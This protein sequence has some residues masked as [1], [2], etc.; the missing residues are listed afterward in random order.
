M[1]KNKIGIIILNYNSYQ[2]SKNC[3]ESI[4][5]YLNTINALIIVVDNASY[6]GS[7]RKLNLE[8]NSILYIRNKKNTGYT[9]GNNLGI[10]AAI[11]NGCNLF[12]ILNNDTRITSKKS[13]ETAI[14]LL[15][16]SDIGICGFKQRS[17]TTLQINQHSKNTLF[18][19]ILNRSLGLKNQKINYLS[20]FAL[21]IKLETIHSIGYLP[22]HFFMYFEEIYYCYKA[23]INNI[24]IFE[25]EDDDL[26][27]IRNDDN[28]SEHVYFW[29]YNIRNGLYFLREM[30]LSLIYFY[31]LSIFLI[32]RQFITLI[33]HKNTKLNLK[34]HIHGI[35]DF[36]RSVKS[37]SILY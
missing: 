6:D 35:I 28:K 9:G 29:Y 33:T 5:K 21:G 36:K 26:A 17:S 15:S 8:Y 30:N 31:T 32:T 3:I 10:K 20:G 34:A 4:K 22:E 27:I 2:N 16:N 18:F 14:N 24:K 19:K 13:I 25:I 11:S 23:R 12:L 37:K 1:K 7:G